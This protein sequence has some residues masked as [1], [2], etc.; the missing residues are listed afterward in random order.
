MD[1]ET[2]TSLPMASSPP[3]QANQG[4]D[5]FRGAH[6]FSIENQYNIGEQTIVMKSGNLGLLDI[7]NPIP[8]ASYTRNRKTSPPDS[9][10]LPGT[11]QDVLK[12]VTSWA[13]SSLLGR[14]NRPVMWLYGYVGCGKPAIAQD[15]AE[16]YARKKRWR[17]VTSSFA[18]LETGA[19][20]GGFQL[21]EESAAKL[22]AEQF[23]RFAAEFS[24]NCYW[25]F[26]V[27]ST[28][29]GIQHGSQMSRFRLDDAP[30]VKS[31]FTEIENIVT[32]IAMRM[33]T[34]TGSRRWPS[35]CLYPDVLDV[36]GPRILYLKTPLIHFH[37]LSLSFDDA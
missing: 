16:H 30:S 18:V 31:T 7:L 20:L 8:D 36:N 22:L 3:S 12:K 28:D 25:E 6:N 14:N 27:I 15:V 11:R 2:D 34:R 17:P 21:E 23:E 35:H 13:D 26:Y 5:F 37:L 29:T 4:T 32:P 33:N 24:S 10:C 1:Q 19:R 9:S